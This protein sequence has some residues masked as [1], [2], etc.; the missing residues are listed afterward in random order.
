MGYDLISLRARETRVSSHSRGLQ[1][2]RWSGG[3]H[4]R[5]NRSRGIEPIDVQLRVQRTQE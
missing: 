4:M 5:A 3:E 2:V 1:R